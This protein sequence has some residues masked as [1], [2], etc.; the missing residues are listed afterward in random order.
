LAPLNY[1]DQLPKHLLFI[2]ALLS[3]GLGA[4]AQGEG[5]ARASA[6]AGSAILIDDAWANFH[7]PAGL[8]NVTQTSAGAFYES[9]FTIKELADKGFMA[10]IPLS[11]SAFGVSYRSFGY[12]AFNS[13]LAAVSYGLNLSEKFAA[14]VKLNYNS[15]RIAEGYGVQR[16]MTVEAGFTFKLTQKLTLAGH[17]INPNQTKLTSFNDERIQS[18]IHFGGGYKFSKKVQLIAEVKKFSTNKF[19]PSMAVEYWPADSFVLRVGFGGNPSIA[20]FGFGWK[21]KALQADF[22]AAYHNVLGFIPQLSLLYTLPNKAATK[23]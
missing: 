21:T 12:S 7:N 22:A 10:A 15:Y 13:S 11:K 4:N 1:P 18:Q 3:L 6:L 20:S 23:Q 17:L 16:A 9:R 8:A 5:G 2:F 14:G 19:K